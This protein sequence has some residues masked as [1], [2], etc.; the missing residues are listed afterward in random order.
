MCGEYI[1]FM[2]RDGVYKFN[3]ASVTKINALPKQLIGEINENAVSASLQD[4]Y[5]L[6]LR[7]NFGDNQTIGCENE[8]D[9]VNNALIKLDLHDNSFQ[10]LRG[11]D[12]KD[13]LALKAGFEE[14]IIATFNSANK[15][16]IGEIL[17]NG[18]CFEDVLC[19]HYSS[20]YFIQT[21]ME[22]ITL[23]NITFEASKDVELKIITDQG[24]YR[25]DTYCDGINKFQTIINCK[26][27]KIEI[28]SNAL[29]PYVNAVQI[30]YIKR[31]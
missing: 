14:K 19:K 31:K 20:N 12:I 3:G 15:A 23:R 29:E 2:T 25:F 1:V 26:K 17:S 9:M 30:E 13:M 7:L 24:E 11:V 21:E 18:Q 8:V 16:R 10:I 28:T 22:D 27:F 4:K 6:A 5:Y